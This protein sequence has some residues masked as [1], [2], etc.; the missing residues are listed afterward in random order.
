MVT[1][2]IIFSEE[3]RKIIHEALDWRFKHGPLMEEQAGAELEI[4]VGLFGDLKDDESNY[5]IDPKTGLKRSI[6]HGFCF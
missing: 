6:M 2:E 4:L 3:Q 5:C 1:F